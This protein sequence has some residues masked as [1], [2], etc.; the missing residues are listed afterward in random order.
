MRSGKRPSEKQ[1]LEAVSLSI[2]GTMQQSSLF[3]F[4]CEA[5]GRPET[6]CPVCVGWR[7]LR[8]ARQR[9]QVVYRERLVMSA[10]YRK[11]VPAEFMR[12]G[13]RETPF[14][15]VPCPVVC[16][17]LGGSEPRGTA[18]RRRRHVAAQ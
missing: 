1:G 11:V 5:R 2:S 6:R 3:V 16:P 13:N 15:L 7:H 12:R 17:T 8:R 18:A 14:V 10:R 4:Y 9:Q